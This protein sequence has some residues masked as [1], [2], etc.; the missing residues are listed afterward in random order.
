MNEGADS[1]TAAST[2]SQSPSSTSV[3]VAGASDTLHHRRNN[4]SD[5]QNSLEDGSTG[6]WGSDPLGGSFATA[7]TADLPPPAYD[8]TFRTAGGAQVLESRLEKG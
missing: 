5:F 7:L 3:D 8:M 2:Y 6:T 1:L 4:T